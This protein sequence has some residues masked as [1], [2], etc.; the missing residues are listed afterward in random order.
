MVEVQGWRPKVQGISDRFLLLCP[1]H[2]QG[3][4]ALQTRDGVTQK[5]VVLWACVCMSVGGL[6]LRLWPVFVCV[7]VGVHCNCCVALVGVCACRLATGVS[8]GFAPHTPH[9]TPLTC[10]SP[11][12]FVAVVVVFV[13]FAFFFFS[14][15]VEKE[16]GAMI[17]TTEK[18]RLF[19]NASVTGKDAVSA[20]C[21]K[22]VDLPPVSGELNGEC[23][24]QLVVALGGFL[25]CFLCVME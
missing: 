15:G 18:M 2:R 7:W 6:T 10:F 4:F 24:L 1:G 5:E 9:S 19:H 25:L 3:E 20:Y 22:V 23:I 16:L 11:F 21:S 8:C 13:L 12:C 17:L 14:V